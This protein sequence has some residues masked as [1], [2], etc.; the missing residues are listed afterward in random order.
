MNKVL[1]KGVGDVFQ[2]VGDYASPILRPWA[3]EVVKTHGEMVLAGKGYPAP[4]N[5]CWPNDVPY[6]LWNVDMQ[7]LHRP[8]H[9]TIIYSNDQEGWHVR[10]NE[11]HPARPAPSWYG[12]SVGHYEGDTL[13]VDTVA[14]KRGP[15]AMMDRYGTAYT[16]ALHVV[17]RYR[18]LDESAAKEA[19]E[20]G[21]RELSHLSKR[22]ESPADKGKAMQVRLTVE[23]KGA[24]AT[25]WS[26]AV[27]YRRLVVEW[28][29]SVCAEN[30]HRYFEED[31][32][33]PVVDKPDF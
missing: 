31:E 17:E 10:L 14:V 12:D 27:T 11:P 26:A 9:I 6:V 33:V 24:F 20:R 23:D 4:N 13:V 3:A 5:Q 15:F 2:L 30:T 1:R 21:Q 29:E 32:K 8:D 18:L 7:M 19:E 28:R 25:P 16:G 22:P